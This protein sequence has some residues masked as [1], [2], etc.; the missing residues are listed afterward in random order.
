[1]IKLID[2]YNKYK[3]NA[4]IEHEGEWMPL[5][6]GYCKSHDLKVKEDML[7][8]RIGE[9]FT[10]Q[11]FEGNTKIEIKTERDIW[12]TT[13]NI[14]IEIR[15]KRQPS[16]L[17]TTKASVWIH[18]LSVNNVIKGGFIFKV[19]ELRALIKKRQNQ[20]KLKMVMGGDDNMSQLVLLPIKD[21]WSINTGK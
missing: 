15:Y 18:L 2:I 13:G 6:E 14:A 4:Y 17:S 19:D 20:G 7:F 1:V 11:L 16:G 12:E 21:L 5:E 9:E 3:D 8:G 10:Q